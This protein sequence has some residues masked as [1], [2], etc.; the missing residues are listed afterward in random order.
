MRIPKRPLTS[1]RQWR[2]ARWFSE[3]RLSAGLAGTGLPADAASA[4]AGNRRK[5]RGS[6]VYGVFNNTDGST[7][8]DQ[9]PGFRCVVV[10]H[11]TDTSSHRAGGDRPPGP[12]IIIGFFMDT[13]SHRAGGDKM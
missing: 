10:I 8:G 5:S 12:C 13:S 9:P 3:R 11:C 6:F 2:V 1:L 4:G 7:S